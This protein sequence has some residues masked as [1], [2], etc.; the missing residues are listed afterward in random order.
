MIFAAG[1]GTRLGNITRDI[2][3]ALVEINGIPI[4]EHT[5]R[6][7]IRQGF[8]EII[9]NVHHYSDK[10]IDFL[11]L[12]NNFGIRIEIS[13]ETEKL[14]DTGGGLKK[15]A[16][17]FNGN[18][19]F[20]VHNVDVLTDLDLHRLYNTHLNSGA[21]ATLAVR[22]RK[23]VRYLLSDENGVLCGWRN[24]GTREEKI[25]KDYSG[26][27]QEVAFSGIHIIRPELLQNFP[28][29]DVF[30]MIE[31][32]LK[33]AADHRIMTFNHDDTR[34]LDIGRPETLMLAE[35]MFPSL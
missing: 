23:T 26:R 1:R 29:K 28:G 2:P 35:K 8:N 21:F 25:V 11:K 13:D 16:W 31:V 5:I 20:L 34:W 12:K 18:D 6:S 17:F 7:L 14:L 33:L 24:T 19:P 3:K 10:I 27:L 22:H 32:Y 30:S 15:A 4:L 9:M